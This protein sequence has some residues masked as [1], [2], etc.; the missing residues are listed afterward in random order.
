MIL[1]LEIFSFVAFFSYESGILENPINSAPSN[2]YKMTKNPI[3][4]P[5]MFQDIEINFSKGIPSSVKNLET[6]QIYCGPL[7]IME[8]LNTVG[9]NHGVGRID[10]VENRY[11]GLKVQI[12]FRENEKFLFS[13]CIYIFFYFNLNFFRLRKVLLI[14][15]MMNSILISKFNFRQIY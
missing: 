7:K 6:N 9:G 8:F 1:F 5:E 10:I 2:L 3:D 4:A 15:L 13:F 12:I 11:I 14:Y